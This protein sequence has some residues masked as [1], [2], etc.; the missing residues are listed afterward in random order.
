MSNQDDFIIIILLLILKYQLVN[1]E[2][3]RFVH[4]RYRKTF[5]KRLNSLQRRLRQRRIPRVALQE[6]RKSAWRTLLESGNN[7]AM[8]TLTG[9]NMETF[10]WLNRRF[11]HWYN[12]HS[13]F[14][15]PNGC[16]VRLQPRNKGRP[17]L[18]NGKPGT[19]LD[20]LVY[21]FCSPNIR[22]N[23]GVTCWKSD[24]IKGRKFAT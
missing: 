3:E 15:D 16:I 17:R 8:I 4:S 7:E 22:W 9:I 12:S 10:I 11:E 18:I 23:V 19:L 6:P 20:L 13:P 14:V 24:E 2:N 5:H 21:V 1:M